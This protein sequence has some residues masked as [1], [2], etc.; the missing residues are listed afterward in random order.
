MKRYNF[1]RIIP[2]DHTSSIKFDHEKSKE[3]LPMWVADMDFPVADEIVDAVKKRA[4]HP[5]YGYSYIPEETIAALIGWHERR[6][7]VTYEKTNIIPYYSVVAAMNLLIS[8]FSEPEDFVTIMSPVYMCFRSSVHE[9]GRN[10]AVS[11][12]R[13][14]NG[15]YLIDFADL[16]ACLKKSKILLLCSPQNP[17]GRV[18]TE[19]E[20]KKIADLTEKYHVLVLSDEIHSDLILPGHHHTPFVT[21]SKH[22]K[23]NSITLLSCTKT[24]NLAQAGMC[25]M[26]TENAEYRGKIQERMTAFHLGDQNLFATVMTQAAFTHGDAWLDQVLAYLA[27]NFQM[28][29]EFIEAK[30]PGIKVL[31]L[32]GTYLLWLD[33]RT[34]K[35][36]VVDLFENQGHI[37]GLDGVLFGE[38]GAKYYR[39]N[40]ATSRKTIKEMLKRLENAYQKCEN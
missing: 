18:W 19:K 5:I 33:C 27:E 23:E 24:F 25:F 4:R 30:T 34:L 40:I 9:T 10:L 17:V 12:L 38:D 7:G 14:E 32:E 28:V 22:A 35:T 16:E 26:I 39:L 37:F 21:L 15:F 20:L 29:K 8:I 11:P 2:R 3:C 31:P 1:D 6:H 36:G 13:N